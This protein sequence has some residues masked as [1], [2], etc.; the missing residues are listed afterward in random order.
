MKHAQ[1][2]YTL[3]RGRLFFAAFAT[4]TQN[5]L[6]EAYI[7]NT[8]E[9]SANIETESL[10]HFNSDEGIKELDES[11]VLSATRTGNFVTDN[12]S[13]PNLALF[14]FGNSAALTVE[15]AEIADEALGTIRKGLYYQL[16]MSDDTPV[17][18]RNLGIH[19]PSPDGG[20]TPDKPIILM[21][22]ATELVYETDFEI[23]LET[24]RIRIMEDAPNVTDGDAA[25][26]SY[27]FDA[28]TRE[29]IMSG[30]QPIQGAL[31]FVADNPAGKNFDWYMPWVKLSP[32]GDY[33]LKGDDW[34][35][36]PFNVQ[37][38]KRTT[39]SAIYIDGRPMVGAG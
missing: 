22:G 21:Q 27:K 35:S 25:T 19:T 28:Y 24:G 33:A 7:G 15:G 13:V 16:G 34:Q 36:I 26:V 9:F 23:D 32:N 6:G 20:V 18:A 4:G 12:V 39:R 29:R 10:D 5:P 11:I 3:G 38:L 14:F 2:N 17:G 37:I 1:N 30:N 8:P 31:R